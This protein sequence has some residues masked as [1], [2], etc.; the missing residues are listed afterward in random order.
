[1]DITVSDLTTIHSIGKSK[2]E[3]FWDPNLLMRKAKGTLKQ[4]RKVS[5]E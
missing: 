2:N 4:E 3:R 5:D 1:M